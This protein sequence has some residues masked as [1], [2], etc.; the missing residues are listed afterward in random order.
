MKGFEFLRRVQ[1]LGK[2]KG[3]LVRLV[4]HQAKAAM[5]GFSTASAGQP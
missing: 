1:R 2:R 5:R 4:V 3:V